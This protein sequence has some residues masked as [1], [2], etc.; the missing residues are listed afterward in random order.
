MGSQHDSFANGTSAVYME[1]MYDAWQ[2][3]PLSVHSSWR[4]YFDNM[5]AG[6]STP[7]QAPPTLGHSSKDAKLQQILDML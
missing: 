3:D 1:Q 2:K 4:A 7:F 6:H 5:H